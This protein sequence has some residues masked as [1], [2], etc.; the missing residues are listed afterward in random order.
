M[1]S[2]FQSLI[3]LLAV[4]LTATVGRVQAADADPY[5]QLTK[6]QFGQ[7]REPLALI[8]EQI[9]KTAPEEYS[10]IEARLLPILQSSE[11]PKDA[12]RFIC[13]WLSIVGSEKCIPALAAL[14]NDDV[15]SHPARMAL[16]PMPSPTAGDALRNALPQVKGKLLAG[17]IASLG[18]RRDEQAVGALSRL[19]GSDDSLV[20]DTALRALGAI[21]TEQAARSLAN[22]QVSEALARTLARAKITAASHLA[23]AGNRQLAARVY[24]SQ[25]SDQQPRAIRIA[26]LKGLIGALPENEG[27]NLVINTMQGSDTAM[28]D[29]VVSAYISSTDQ[30]LKDAVAAQLPNLRP[31]GQLLL[32]GV[33]ADQT[34]VAARTPVLKVLERSQDTDT[35]DAALECLVRHGTA[36]DV[37]LLVRLA[38]NPTAAEAAAAKSVLQRMQA[39]NVN[40]VLIQLVESPDAGT[41][42]VVLAALASRHAESALPTLA[43]LATGTDPVMAT[44][45]A[46]ALGVMGHT[47][48]LAALTQVLVNTDNTELRNAAEDSA[49][50]IC[51]RATDKAAIAQTLLMAL[52]KARTPA[53]RTSLLPL[54]I[55]PAGEDAMKAA[56]SAMLEGNAE[57]RDAAVRTLASWPDA[58]V[59]PTLVDL[60]KSTDNPTYAVLALRDGCLRLAAMEEVP[61]AERLSIYRSILDA[62]K[63]PQE[64]KQ[65]I[66]GLSQL[67]SVGAMELLQQCMK[68][69]ALKNDASLAA[70]RLARQ[71]GVVYNKQAMAALEQIKA[72]ATGDD[73]RK[74][75]ESAIRAVQNIGQSPEGYIVAWMLAGPYTETGKSGQDLF[76][77]RFAPEKADAKA[78]WR[79]VVVPPGTKAGMV[80]LDKIFGGNDRVAYLRTQIESDEPQNALLE[81]GSDDGVKVWLNGQVVHAN[82]AVR[83]NTPNQDKARIKLKQG[84]NTLLL[85]ITQGG[86]EWTACCRVRSTDGKELNNITIAPSAE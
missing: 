36:E 53:A 15:L 12:K 10:A 74:Q 4:A 28:R 70:V 47:E 40:T 27:A 48:Q 31:E 7:S 17:V 2:S 5:Q 56:R 62:A 49:K 86:G 45:A 68:N 63:R 32:L 85:K 29:A 41:R 75:A 50:S 61:M 13:R 46:K 8:S 6:W 60:A 64:K 16:E 19:A 37:A 42:A 59:V 69:E 67:P 21:G 9:R 73:I 84:V 35:R 55:Y 54:L 72:Q 18:V 57:V 20:A 38:Q 79:P 77:V 34:E 51:R 39:P 76:D 44:E 26:A 80:A 81:I 43:K 25:M 1:K 23:A 11:T 65:A 22:L 71:I 66:S 14:L 24:Q 58:A 82:N 78:D 30:H 83:P 52:T 3:V 33:L